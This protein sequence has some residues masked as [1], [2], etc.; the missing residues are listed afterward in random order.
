MDS[1]AA[2]C[3]SHLIN[4]ALRIGAQY[5][6]KPCGRD[7]IFV[8]VRHALRQP[9]LEARLESAMDAEAEAH[10][11][12][13]RE[14]ELF[15]LKLQHFSHGDIATEWDRKLSTIESTSRS[16]VAKTNAGSIQALVNKV[17]RIARWP[18][19]SQVACPSRPRG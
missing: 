16:L 9:P 13:P 10:D 17:W 15:A 7:E 18:F 11:L 19:V 8:V 4:R 14:R 3:E 5:V 1:S 2:H 6:A 12:T